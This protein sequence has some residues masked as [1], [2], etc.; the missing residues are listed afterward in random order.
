[1]MEKLGVGRNSVREAVKMLSALGVLE[2]RRGDGTYIA[3]KVSS[4]AFDALVYSIMIE[5]SSKE[6]ILEVRKMIEEGILELAVEKATSEDIAKLEIL[7]EELHIVLRERNYEKAAL[8]DLEFHYAL[9]DIAR[10][11]LVT[12]VAKGILQF[13]YLSIKKTLQ[14]QSDVQQP[15][16]KSHRRI[17][18]LLKKGNKK[19]IKDIVT[20]SLE[21]WK[22]NL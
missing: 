12:R 3:Q 9:A 7:L 20:E 18:E 1:M 5:Q 4:S 17:I 6:E 16:N 11:P 10:N 19:A 15:Y 22:N 21:E 14:A 13:F 2:I 8:L